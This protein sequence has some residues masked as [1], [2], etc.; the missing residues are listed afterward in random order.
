MTPTMR[1]IVAA[2]GLALGAGTLAP[3]F[4][5]GDTAGQ[6]AGKFAARMI[7]RFD[8]DKDGKVTLA[9]YLALESERFAKSDTDGDGFITAS[10]IEARSG[11][12]ADRRGSRIL[13]RLDKDG[14]G[15]I[16]AAEADTGQRIKRRFAR[17]DV[18]RDNF[19]TTAELEAA[20]DKHRS[21]RTERLMDRVDADKDKRISVAEAQSAHERRFARLDADKD[22]SVTQAELTES[23]TKMRRG[24]RR[25]GKTEQ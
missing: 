9:G 10:E 7:E 23:L 18:D 11:K 24:K 14:D 20:R 5:Q 19:V 13:E 12:R 16:S 15:R 1:L 6:R 17:L 3:A 2:S 22:G 25:H 4:A 8:G 21:R